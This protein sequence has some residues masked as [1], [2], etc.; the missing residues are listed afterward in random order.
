MEMQYEV[1]GNKNKQTFQKRGDYYTRKG[2]DIKVE[3]AKRFHNKCSVL[4][5]PETIVVAKL[6][7]AFV[8]ASGWGSEVKTAPFLEPKLTPHL[9]EAIQHTVKDMFPWASDN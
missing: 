1:L 8:M 5:Y 3:L 2:Y 4:G 6:V 7:E 9:R